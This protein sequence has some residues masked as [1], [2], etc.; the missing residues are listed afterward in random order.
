MKINFKKYILPIFVLILLAVPSLSF[1]QTNTICSAT[2]ENI[3]DI[4]CKISLILNSFVIPL[5][6]SL[7]VVIF[8][9]GVV[10]YVIA[11]GEE[12]KTK[13]RDRMI[14]GIIGLVVIVSLWG[15]VYIVINTFGFDQQGANIASNFIQS[16]K[17]ILPQNSSGSCD[18]IPNPKL[19][20]LLEYATCVIVKSVVPLILALAVVVFMWGVVQYVMN[21]G[22]E[23][24]KTKGKQ[25]MIWGI[26]SIAVMV[27]VWGLVRVLSNTFDIED[28]IPQVKS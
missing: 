5:L 28:A 16:N 20:N 11:D 27:S 4:L 19:G 24:K 23:E 2:A 10:M 22:E 7:G 6:L 9:W 12:A 21:N 3:G 25:F 18:L 14:F 8:V 26:V 1:A 13:G 17:D 15:I